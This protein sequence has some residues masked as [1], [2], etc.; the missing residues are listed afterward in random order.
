MIVCSGN[1]VSLQG[2]T[3]LWLLDREKLK[4]NTTIRREENEKTS[5]SDVDGCSAGAR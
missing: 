4:H 1:K 5:N 3:F 2:D